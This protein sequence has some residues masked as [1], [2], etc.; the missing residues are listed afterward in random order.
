MNAL[1]KVLI[2]DT[3]IDWDRYVLTQED[4]GRFVNPNELVGRISDVVHGRG[5]REGVP[6]PWAGLQDKVRLRR[7]KFAVWAGINHHGKTAML[8]QIALHLV[9]SGER[10]CMA[11]LEEDPEETMADIAS[12]AMPDV[13]L[14]ETDEYIDVACNW[15]A[16][17]LWLYNQTKMMDP[18]RILALM[19]YA[20]KEKRCTHF[21]LDSLMRTGIAQDDYDGQRIFCNHLT[22]HGS[23]LNLGIHLVHHIVK[24]DEL[25][26]PGRESIRGTGAIVDQ[27]DQTFIVWRDMNED[28]AIEAPDGLLIV[29]KNRGRRPLNWIGRIQMHMHRSGQ[30]MRNKFD[31]PMLFIGEMQ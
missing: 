20:A 27:S 30:F 10:V 25:Q 28:K 2:Q 24:V 22:N 3:P 23:R 17:K 13:D 7:G 6:L 4:L 18:Q 19:A 29:A 8:K 14:R 26:V 1:A 31:Q 21:I 16:G 15:S 11:S 12:L 9:R 5:A